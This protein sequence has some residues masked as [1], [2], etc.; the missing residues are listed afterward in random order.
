MNRDRALLVLYLTAVVAATM[1]HN[2]AVLAAGLAVTLIVAGRDAGR[3]LKRSALAVAAFTSLVTVAYVALAWWRGEI[4]WYFV[5]LLNTRVLLLTSLSVLFAMR[6]NPFRA[7]SFSRTLVHV[8]TVATSQV[9]AF[10]RLHHDFRLAFT[11]R[12]AGPVRARD[13]YRHAAA[14]ASFFIRRALRETTD[15]TMAM[16]SRGFFDDSR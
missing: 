14:T 15:I 2:A 7:L 8:V 12:S 1:I 3:V 4:S 9:L 16:T 11:S 13:R 5:V 10:R 6:V